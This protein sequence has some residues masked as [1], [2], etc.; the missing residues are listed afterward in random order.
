MEGAHKRQRE[1]VDTIVGDKE[2]AARKRRRAQVVRKLER[3]ALVVH[4]Q[5]VWEDGQTALEEADEATKLQQT[6]FEEYP[7]M[8]EGAAVAYVLERCNAVDNR[9]A[10]KSAKRTR[11]LSEDAAS[12]VDECAAGEM[13]QSLMRV[14]G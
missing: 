2:E 3:R 14:Q 6:H 10:A 8:T 4:R 1:L 9:Q 5:N 13:P 11:G 12:T 7:E